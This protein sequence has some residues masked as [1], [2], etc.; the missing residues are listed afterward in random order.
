MRGAP[1]D[2]V[3]TAPEDNVPRC[4]VTIS[5]WE[6]CSGRTRVKTDG[7]ETQQVCE[8]FPGSPLNG[9]AYEELVH[10]GFNEGDSCWVSVDIDG[11]ETNHQ[12]EDNFTLKKFAPVARYLLEGGPHNPSWSLRQ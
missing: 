6:E 9:W 7:R 12:S 8:G 11:G 1:P 10:A 2:L 4:A 3:W 5:V